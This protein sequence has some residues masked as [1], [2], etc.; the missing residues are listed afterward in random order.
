M[1]IEPGEELTVYYGSQYGNNYIIY[2]NMDVRDIGELPGTAIMNKHIATYQDIIDIC[3]KKNGGW[4]E[5]IDS[6]EDS[7]NT[8]IISSDDDI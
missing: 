1:D 7:D 2:N 8:I 6:V 3:F 4:K 5:I